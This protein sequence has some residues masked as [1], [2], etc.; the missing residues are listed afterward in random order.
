MWPFDPPT[1]CCIVKESWGSSIVAE[2]L[3]WRV[4]ASCCVFFFYSSSVVLY[5][6]S[7]Y[8]PHSF[9]LV[10]ASPALEFRVLLSLDFFFFSCALLWQPA[11][12]E[13]HPHN[14][15]KDLSTEWLPHCLVHFVPPMSLLCPSFVHFGLSYLATLKANGLPH[16]RSRSDTF[17]GPTLV[18]GPAW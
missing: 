4:S 8:S 14:L 13:L 7:L 18:L 1:S 16:V 10:L 2:V 5:T 9:R 17:L 11:L 6:S 15:R 3:S 12:S